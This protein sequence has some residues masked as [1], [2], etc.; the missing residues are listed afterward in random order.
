MK[1]HVLDTFFYKYCWAVKNIA[2]LKIR[3]VRKGERWTPL[4]KSVK[5]SVGASASDR[6]P[7]RTK[8]ADRLFTASTNQN[9][10]LY[11][12]YATETYEGVPIDAV[13]LHTG[14]VFTISRQD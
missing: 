1:K 11:M 3:V 2:V 8:T 9:T 13:Q 10:A 6:S 12:L 7:F 4:P 5:A 14:C